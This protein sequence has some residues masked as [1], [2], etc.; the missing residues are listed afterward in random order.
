MHNKI[1]RERRDQNRMKFNTA[2]PNIPRK[3]TYSEKHKRI[4]D[5]TKK[6]HL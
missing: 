1:G 3:E 6:P 2:L 4:C 5:C